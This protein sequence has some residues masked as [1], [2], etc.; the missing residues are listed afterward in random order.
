MG[1]AMRVNFVDVIPD[2]SLR[3]IYLERK[4]TGF[5]FCVRLSYYRGHFLSDIDTLEVYVDGEKVSEADILSCLNEKELTIRQ[6]QEAYT[7]FWRLLDPALIIVHR[8]GGLTD[9]EHH[10][11][12]N[13]M[14]RVPYLPLPGRNTDHDYMPLDAGGEKT[15]FLT[16]KESGNRGKENHE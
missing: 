1:F 10:I 16:E 11:R 7:E 2:N 5:C 9:G 4:I 6:L 14:M 15:F 3:N 12:L 8:P 13:L